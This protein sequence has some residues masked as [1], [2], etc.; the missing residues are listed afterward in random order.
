MDLRSDALR[1]LSDPGQATSAAIAFAAL[2]GVAEGQVETQVPAMLLPPSSPPSQ[3]VSTSQVFQAAI[4]QG[5]GLMVLTTENLSFLATMDIS[6]GAKA[7]ITQTV[8]QG[9]SVIG[10][11]AERHLERHPDNGLVSSRSDHG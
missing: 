7:L 10:A 5:V 1:V 4:T 8:E 11:R 3:S 9:D 6:A 2:R